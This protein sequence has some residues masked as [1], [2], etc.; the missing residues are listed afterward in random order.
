MKFSGKDFSIVK[1]NIR[2]QGQIQQN[3]VIESHQEIMKNLVSLKV[4]AVSKKQ[5][6]SDSRTLEQFL[7]CEQ[8]WAGMTFGSSGLGTGMDNSI[9]EIREGEG[10]EK[11][12]HQRW[13]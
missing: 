2:S 13:R 7:Q 11:K 3:P 1:V 10:N 12:Y 6:T 8:G 5:N 4:F 9:P